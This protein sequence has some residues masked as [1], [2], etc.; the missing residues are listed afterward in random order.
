M[1]NILKVRSNL[2]ISLNSFIVI[3]FCVAG[4]ML[5]NEASFNRKSQLSHIYSFIF[6][7]TQIFDTLSSCLW[8]EWNAEN[9]KI[10]LIFLSN[11]LKP[12]GF[13]FAGVILDYKFALAVS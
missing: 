4:Q 8:Y 10:L 9:K 2:M 11:G 12:L 7:T 1:S 3:I 13:S 6:Q 5:L